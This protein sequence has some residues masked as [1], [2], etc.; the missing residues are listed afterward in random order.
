MKTPPPLGHP[1]GLS[2][3]TTDEERDSRF[4]V[5]LG[6]VLVAASL[7]FK[8]E[9]IA[10]GQIWALGGGLLMVA[11]PALAAY[12]RSESRRPSIEHFIP[13]ALGSAAVAGLSLLVPEWWKY[14]LIVG[15]FGAGFFAASH[16]D[17]RQVRAQLKP[18]HVVI[19]EVVMAL[20][21]A[22]CFLVVLAV[23]FPLP[24]RLACV[25][26]LS[27]VATYRSFRLLGPPMPQRR[28]LLF[29]LFVAQL[30]A[31]FAWAM[32]AYLYYTEGALAVMLFL[33]WYVNRGIIRHT[34]EEAL[35]RNV[36]VEYGLFVILIAYLFFTSFQLR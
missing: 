13:L 30:V 14:G 27:L 29:S 15:L 5:F 22:A 12:L 28:A 32:S 11:A 4:L 16:L 8:S 1:V 3:S 18:G 36:L 33:L 6:L 7:G 9:L 24:L 25:F 17:H 21:L 35:N 34:V 2:A 10:P 20:A 23:N 19:Q 26:L 31:F